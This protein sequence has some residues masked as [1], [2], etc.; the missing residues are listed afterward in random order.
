M[1]R[2]PG[3]RI[4]FN[5]LA[6]PCTPVF[7]SLGAAEIAKRALFDSRFRSSSENHGT[8]EGYGSTR[9]GN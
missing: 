1:F 6:L 3:T 9:F 7:E 2:I 8:A 4:F 5:W